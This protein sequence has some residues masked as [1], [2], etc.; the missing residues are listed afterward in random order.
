M[1]FDMEAELRDLCARRDIHDALCRYMRGQDRLDP[2]LHR[3]AFH[4]DA[5][6]DCGLMQGSADEFVAFAQ[7]F[8]ADL[9][10][11]QHIIGQAQIEVRGEQASG[12]VYFCAWHRLREEDGPKDL[13]V[14]GRYVDEYTCKNGEWRISR[15]REIVD[16]ARTDPAADGFLE[17]NPLVRP[18]R[19]GTDFSQTR[20]W[21][22]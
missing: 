1:A 14:A 6:V 11:S 21:P 15:R 8:L 5:W 7:G 2:E 18:G 13:I 4:D 3:S 12:E 9:D 19:R 20:D 10:G 22:V 17:G 16:W